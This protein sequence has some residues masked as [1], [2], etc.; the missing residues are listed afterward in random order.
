MV[1]RLKDSI[2][3]AFELKL[4]KFY[5]SFFEKINADL[6]PEILTTPENLDEY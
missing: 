4:K 1:F 3:N 2:E 6:M 5:E